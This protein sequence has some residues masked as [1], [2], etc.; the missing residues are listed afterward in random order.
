MIP[1]LRKIPASL[2]QQGTF[3]FLVGH[4][5]PAGENDQQ[6]VRNPYFAVTSLMMHMYCPLERALLEVAAA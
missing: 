5:R 2:R 6:R 1:S 4:F 3:L